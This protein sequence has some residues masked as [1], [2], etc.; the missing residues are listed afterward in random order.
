MAHAPERRRTSWPPLSTTLLLA[1][2]LLLLA[3]QR[4]GGALPDG[5]SG[6]FPE[7]P[8]GS[9]TLVSLGDFHGALYE[10]NL[11]DDPRRAHGGLPWLASAVATLRQQHPRLL[12]L[13]AGDLFQGAIPVNASLGMGAVQAMNLIGLDATV[14]GNHDFDYGGLPG[15]HPLRGALK[16]AMRASKFPWLAANIRILDANNE[17]SP[18]R[19][20]GIR[21]WTVVERD[22]VK[23]ALIG[24]STTHT[25]NTTLPKHVADLRFDDPVAT[26]L[27][28][29]DEV[30]KAAPHLT[31][32]L[33][34]LSG[35]CVRSGDGTPCTFDGEV[36]DLLAALPPGKVDVIIA[37]HSHAH[38]LNQHDGVW[39]MQGG[40]KG[41][42]LAIL[43]VPISAGV[44]KL[45]AAQGRLWHLVHDRVEPGC[46]GAPFPMDA[47]DVGGTLL[48]PS[49]DALQLVAALET[50]A[51]AG[52]CEV[53]ACADEP[54]RRAAR[55]ESALGNLAAD[56]ARALYP[57]ADIGLQNAGG[58]RTDLGAGEIRREDVQGLMPFDN[59][60]YLVTLDGAQLLRVLQVGTAGAHGLIQVSGLRYG[61]HDGCQNPVDLNGDGHVAPWEHDCLCWVEVAGRPLDPSA[62]YRVAVNNYLVDGGDRMDALFAN[63]PISERGVLVRDAIVRHLQQG[64]QGCLSTATLVD[65]E[66]PRI[67]AATCH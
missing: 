54:L 44:A 1:I 56:A 19:P 34:H 5:Q 18:W 30:E 48:R 28:L 23:V 10:S 2:A 3:C 22:G 58:L 55:A 8:E 47:L 6:T 21:P 4:E 33:G 39:V 26:T 62:T 43:E 41:S 61:Y 64:E 38:H 40:A 67:V 65:Q 11:H 24:L 7:P 32:I 53:V 60:I 51:G 42:H 12:L 57:G 35:E 46:S 9:L 27:A 29:L 66:A 13:D 45:D 63:A 15:V 14:V 59:E 20:P 50:A 25:P 31:V 52:R 37:G 36:G 49:A 17:A 16:A